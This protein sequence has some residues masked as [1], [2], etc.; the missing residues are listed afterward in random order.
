MHRF[1]IPSPTRAALLLF[2]VVL[3]GCTPP[4]SQNPAQPPK[5]GV[6]ATPKR[7]S[8]EVKGKPHIYETAEIRKIDQTVGPEDWAD[9]T[10]A[11]QQMPELP[12]I[13][14]LAQ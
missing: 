8:P 3:A 4:A 5:A 12:Y 11:G 14:K 2:V 10:L 1:Q 6:T 13:A 7:P 9:E